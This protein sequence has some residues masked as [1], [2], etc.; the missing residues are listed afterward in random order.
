MLLK[1]FSSRA[2]IR[3]AMSFLLSFYVLGVVARFAP[4]SAG[5]WEGLFDGVRGALMGIAIALIFLGFRAR[6]AES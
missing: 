1:K 5:L 2:L 3:V 4:P 6:R